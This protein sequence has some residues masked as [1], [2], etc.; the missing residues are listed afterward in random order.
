MRD[1]TKVRK[2]YY[3]LR[4]MLR[5]A[6]NTDKGSFCALSFFFIGQEYPLY[7][8]IMFAAQEANEH[9]DLKVSL[10]GRLNK[11]HKDKTILPTIHFA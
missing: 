2:D 9:I 3:L 5:K 6:N 11:Y 4:H 10:G 1:A 8:R 7:T